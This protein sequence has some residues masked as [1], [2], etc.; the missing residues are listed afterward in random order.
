MLHTV[1]NERILIQKIY[2]KRKALLRW[3]QSNSGTKEDAEDVLQESMII[4]LRLCKENKVEYREDP[5]GL[6]FL[7]GKRYWLSK[8]RK[9]TIPLVSEEDWDNHNV[10]EAELENAIE[11]EAELQLME[12]GLE[13]LGEKC[14]KLLELFYYRNFSMTQIAQKLGFRNEHVARSM[15]YKCLEKAKLIITQ[16]SSL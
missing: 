8:L 15:K 12:K 16:K 13:K 3:V 6:I 9:R 5:H 10:S 4:Y 7:I 11:K 1:K 2:R 14:K